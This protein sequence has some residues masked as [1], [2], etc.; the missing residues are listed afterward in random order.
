MMSLRQAQSGF[1]SHVFLMSALFFSLGS[2][3]LMIGFPLTERGDVPN[4]VGWGMVGS[5]MGF[6][7][8]MASLICGS[9]SFVRN[10]KTLL[11]LSRLSTLLLWAGFLGFGVFSVLALLMKGP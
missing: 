10:E 5:G 6:W 8:A 9:A 2:I 1:V 11:S 3:A 4:W 7:L